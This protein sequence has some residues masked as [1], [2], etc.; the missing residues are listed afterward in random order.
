[1]SKPDCLDK[2]CSFAIGSRDF[3]NLS[4][5]ATV[6]LPHDNTIVRDRCRHHLV[7]LGDV[8]GNNISDV[9]TRLG[10]VADR[11]DS[12]RHSRLGDERDV[13][14]PACHTSA[15]LTPLLEEENVRDLMAVQV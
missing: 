12:I 9:L 10:G 8:N 4:C 3:A 11:F 6:G 7:F 13:A 15:L 1:M 5:T 2:V 14:L